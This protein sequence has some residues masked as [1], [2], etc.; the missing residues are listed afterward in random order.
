MIGEK[1]IE[2][3]LPVGT[4][5]TFDSKGRPMIVEKYEKG[6]LHGISTEYKNGNKV[7]V[8]E[9]RFGNKYGPSYEYFESG[10]TKIEANYELNRLHG[11]YTSYFK[12]YQ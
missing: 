3:E 6:K 1:Q 12:N 11:A 9:Y 8:T 10:E 2:N 5:K 4:W 7:I